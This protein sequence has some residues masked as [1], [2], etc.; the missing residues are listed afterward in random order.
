MVRGNGIEPLFTASKA[1][2]LPL[3]DP[4]SRREYKRQELNFQVLA[5]GDDRCKHVDDC[6]H[7]ELGAENDVPVF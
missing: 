7:G 2:V 4:R 3:D 1:A 5:H 6:H